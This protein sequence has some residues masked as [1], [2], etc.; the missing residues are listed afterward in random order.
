MVCADTLIASLAAV[1]I[2]Y[3][4]YA[5]A[6]LYYYHDDRP[7]YN[8]FHKSHGGLV[9]DVYATISF[10]F[11]QAIK[12]AAPSSRRY[13]NQSR[14]VIT[15]SPIIIGDAGTVQCAVLK[16]VE[17]LISSKNPDE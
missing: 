11:W 12:Y 7:Y 9:D 4:I 1:E 14:R 8:Y 17:A 10:T 5:A 3:L 16:K 15:V 13:P 2:H 6:L